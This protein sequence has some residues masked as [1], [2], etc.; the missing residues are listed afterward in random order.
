MPTAKKRKLMTHPTE[1]VKH[2]QLFQW[3]AKPT[4]V[5]RKYQM[6]FIKIPTPK[7]PCLRNWILNACLGDSAKQLGF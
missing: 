5:I 1:I 6:S 2:T 7:T 4:E 3:L